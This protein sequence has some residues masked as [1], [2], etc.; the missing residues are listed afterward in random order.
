MGRRNREETKKDGT[1]KPV[2]YQDVEEFAGLLSI[3]QQEAPKRTLE[4]GSLFGGTLWHWMDISSEIVVVDKI[5]PEG[6]ERRPKQVQ[7]HREWPEWALGRCKLTIFEEDSGLE[8]T[9]A[10]VKNAMPEVDFLFIDGDHRYEAVKKDFDYYSPLVR[11]GGIIAFHDI[12]FTDPTDQYYGVYPLWTRLEGQHRTK[13]FVTS[14]GQFG[15]GVIFWDG[16]K[17]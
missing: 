4:I 16:G 7:A 17:G 2:M 3:I 1:M 10:G 14:W 15:I 6:D 12:A 9:V 13:S 11:P 8:T 5:I